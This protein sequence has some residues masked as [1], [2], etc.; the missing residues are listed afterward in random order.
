MSQGAFAGSGWGGMDLDLTGNEVSEG[1]PLLKAGVYDA[2][3]GNIEVKA[4]KTGKALKV[5]FTDVNG[6]GQISF[7][8]NFINSS[9]E[10]Q[11]IGRDQLK[12]FLTHGGHVDPDHPF[13]HPQ[14]AMSG[15]KVRIYVEHDGTYTKNNRTYDSFSIKRFAPVSDTPA[16]GPAPVQ[17]PAASSARAS[18]AAASPYRPMDDD[19]PF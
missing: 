4:T 17:Q 11:R 13:Q 12:T 19:I 3:S 5:I 18:G 15:L 10:A 1:I 14:E 2:T 16:S 9:T 6:T 8:F 7:N